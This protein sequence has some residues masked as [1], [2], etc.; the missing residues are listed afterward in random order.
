MLRILIADDH[1]VVRQGIMRIIEDTP[2][3]RVTGE[4]ENGIEAIKK[5]KK[6]N[7]IWWCWIFQ[8]QARDGLETIESSKN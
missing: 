2:D 7:L 1:P 6:K 4:A 8:C 3:M 5:I